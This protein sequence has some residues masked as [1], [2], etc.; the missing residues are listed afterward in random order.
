MFRE[1]GGVA[2]VEAVELV[3]DQRFQPGTA[4]EV[5]E[6]VRRDGEAVRHV[7]ARPGEFADHF[8]QRGVFAAHQRDVIDADLAKPLD[9]WRGLHAVGISGERSARCRGIAIGG[10]TLAA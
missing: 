3:A 7:H 5:S 8:T 2:D 9:E 6:R 4:D 1:A 10:W